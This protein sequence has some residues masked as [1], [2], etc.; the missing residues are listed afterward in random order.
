MMRCPHCGEY[1][2]VTVEHADLTGHEPG[3]PSSHSYCR[4][5]DNGLCCGVC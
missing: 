4:N 3:C 1:E 2:V 5:C